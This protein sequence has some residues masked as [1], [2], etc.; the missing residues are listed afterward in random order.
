MLRNAILNLL[1]K[2]LRLRK[3]QKVLQLNNIYIKLYD[4]LTTK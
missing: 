2:C 1:Q 3:L 4:C